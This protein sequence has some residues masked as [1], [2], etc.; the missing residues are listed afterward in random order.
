MRVAIK[1]GGRLAMGNIVEMELFT[2]TSHG[3]VAGIARWC[4]KRL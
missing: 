2:K 4:K 1:V 3:L